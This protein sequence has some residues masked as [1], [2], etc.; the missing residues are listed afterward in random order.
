M[1]Q[2]FIPNGDFDFVMMAEQF[3]RTIATDPKRFA[4][5]AGE[6]ADLSAATAAYRVALN[7]AR[8]AARTPMAT[9]TKDAARAVVERIVRRMAA[10]IR[11]SDAVD[12]AAKGLLNLRERPAKAK[13]VPCPDAPPRL[14]FVRALHEGNGAAPLHELEFRELHAFSN[15]K[16]AG[17]VR[18]ELFVD[19]ILPDEAVPPYPVANLAGRPWYL[20][21]YTRS[22]IVVAPP[23]TRVPMRVIYWGRWADST[24]NVGPFSATAAAWI[25]GGSAHSLPGGVGM[26]VPGARKPAALIETA[27]TA[28]GREQTI[29]VLVLE[30]QY[31]SL[32]QSGHQSFYPQ[33]MVEAGGQLPGVPEA[34]RLEGREEQDAA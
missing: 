25:E 20:R 17:A 11:V 10:V 29:N 16:P 19:L 3:E 13:Q 2:K 8:G 9:R 28:G 26:T 7:A 27:A 18:L 33:Q 12:A 15:R 22:P 24:G 4:V 5:T 21:S 32:R 6:A 23:M 31:Q 34:R 30:A 1:S 14:K